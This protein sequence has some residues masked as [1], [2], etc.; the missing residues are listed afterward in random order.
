MRQVDATCV[1]DLL[2]S[3]RVTLLLSQAGD[4]DRRILL[5]LAQK[6]VADPRS[7]G[8]HGRIRSLL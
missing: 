4:S 5:S 3:E 8:S 1:L 6:I 7:R 2:L